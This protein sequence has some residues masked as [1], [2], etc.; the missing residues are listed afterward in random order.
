MKKKISVRILTA[1]AGAV[2]LMM[3]IG[4]ILMIALGIVGYYLSRIYREVQ[5]RPKYMISRKI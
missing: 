1:L 4:S 5:G 3:L 2:L